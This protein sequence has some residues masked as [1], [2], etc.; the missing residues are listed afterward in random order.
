MIALSSP[1]LAASRAA[2]TASNELRVGALAIDC[3]L[4][5]YNE[6]YFYNWSKSFEQIV[7]VTAEGGIEQ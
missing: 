4:E 6:A 3:N 1:S 5:L 7:R 2:S